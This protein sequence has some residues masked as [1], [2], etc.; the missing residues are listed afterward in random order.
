M[1]RVIVFTASLIVLA[2][3]AGCT[4]PPETPVIPTAEQVATGTDEPGST[5]VQD[6]PPTPE[7]PTLTPTPEPP[8]VGAGPFPVSFPTADGVTLHGTLYG[9]GATGVILAPMYLIGQAGW[10]AFAEALAAQGYRVL[11]YDS[12]GSGESEGERAP[13]AAAD[14]LAAAVAFMRSHEFTPAVLI[15]AGIG[16]S[17]A[18]KTA[19][20][21]AS[22][23]GVVVISAPRSF[24][25]LE[26][27]DAE[28]EALA[29]PSLWIAT[30][31]DMIQNVEPMYELAASSDKTLWIYEGSSLQGTFIFEGA[32]TNDLRQRL[33]DFV[34]RVTGA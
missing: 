28:L 9:E 4:P 19:A 20:Q 18:V 13:A 12:R 10:S 31:N 15:G 27:T 6:E 11:V 33:I 2:A 7:S 24:E 5:P 3:L 1:H 22:F 30:R 25:G 32:D 17:A 16:G 29:S 26:V 23:A 34:V 21:D 8:F 14:D